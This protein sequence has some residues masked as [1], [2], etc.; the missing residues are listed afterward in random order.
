LFGDS[1]RE[2]QQNLLVYL[3]GLGVFA[4]VITG[5]EVNGVLPQ[6]AEAFGVSSAS[7]GSW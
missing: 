4:A 3:L 5:M 6:L 2:A 7:T 1:R